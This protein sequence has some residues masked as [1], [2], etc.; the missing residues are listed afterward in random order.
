MSRAK[1]RSVALKRAPKVLMGTVFITR[2]VHF[3]AA[4]RLFNPSKS[5]AWNEKVFGPCANPNWHGHNDVLEVTVSGNPDPETG[6][7]MN[8]VDLKRIINEEIVDACDHRN[9]NTEVGFLRG[10][11]PTAENLVIAF[12]NQLQPRMGSAHLHSVRL[13]ETPRNYAE[14]RG[15][16]APSA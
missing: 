15:P 6:Y 16:G 1:Q 4:H 3:N 2:Q 5:R 11:I 8:L 12:W 9:L 13:F 10:V 14:Y 7:V